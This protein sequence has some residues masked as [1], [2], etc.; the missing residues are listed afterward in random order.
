[1]SRYWAEQHDAVC[2][3]EQAAG[4]VR[5]QHCLRRRLLLTFCQH[6]STEMDSDA[7]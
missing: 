6:C 1:M 2:A 5:C 7:I 3:L 4:S